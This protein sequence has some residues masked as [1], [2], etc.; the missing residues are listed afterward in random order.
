MIVVRKLRPVKTVE[1]PEGDSTTERR[2][3]VCEP[4]RDGRVAGERGL[5]D[6][7]DE[8]ARVSAGVAQGADEIADQLARTK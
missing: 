2:E 5:G 8:Q 7:A 3:L 6:L 1:V 4:V